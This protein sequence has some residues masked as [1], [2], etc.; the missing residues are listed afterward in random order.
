MILAHNFFLC[1]L[2]ISQIVVLDYYGGPHFVTSEDYYRATLD[3]YKTSLNILKTDVFKQPRSNV[4]I[5]EAFMLNYLNDEKDA[6]NI[7]TIN[8]EE[9]GRPHSIKIKFRKN[10]SMDEIDIQL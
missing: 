10:R 3:E 4:I 5:N 9:I 8:E 2:N 1:K 6:E 7:Q